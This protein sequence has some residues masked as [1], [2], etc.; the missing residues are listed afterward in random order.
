MSAARTPLRWLSFT[1][2]DG[3]DGVSTLDAEASSRD[4]EAVAGMRAEAERVIAWARQ[5]FAASEG[6]VEDGADWD[7]H[8]HQG[9]EAGG[10]QVLAL[11]FSASARFVSAFERA[12]G[13]DGA[14]DD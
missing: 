3:D 11:T 8:L 5:R 13:L 9:V 10:W 1:L 14:Q 2:S 6:A 4:P 12:F 7:H